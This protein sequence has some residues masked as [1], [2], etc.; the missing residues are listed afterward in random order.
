M[1]DVAASDD[2][3][4]LH[5]QDEWEI[6]PGT[7]YLNHGS[8]GPPPKAVKH[9]QQQWKTKLDSQPMRFFLRQMPDA[10]VEARRKMAEFVGTGLDDLVFVENSTYGMNVVAHSFPLQPGDEVLLNDHEYGAVNRI[11]ER[12]CRQSGA[13]RVVARLPDQIETAEDVVAAI[14]NAVTPSTRLIV[15]SHITSPTAIT[16]PVAGICAAAKQ[17]GVAVCIDGAHAVAHLPLNI[18]EL[19]CDF[20]T[21]TCHKWLCA[22]FGSGLLYVSPQW[23]DAIQ[24]PV[25]SWGVIPPAT[26]QCWTEEFGWMGTRD[27]SAF[28]ATS[29]AIDFL[30]AIGL[31]AF[32]ERTFHLAQYGLDQIL[33]VTD[34]QPLTPRTRAWSGC[35]SLAPLPPCDTRDI[36]QRLIDMAGIES[37]LVDLNDRQY[38]RLSAHLYTQ[39]EQFDLLAGTLRKFLNC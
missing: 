15:V 22:P 27:P 23:Q 35:M 13:T 7:V 21:A 29:A 17:R 10:I 24:P 3:A 26:P 30:E 8:F 6:A 4:W 25:L 31:E 37:Q 19:G 12:K 5:L 28:L 14:M 9:Y 36:R 11:W 20:Y 39:R 38:I 33:Q 32:R 1:T 34:T 2:E 18:N 16:L